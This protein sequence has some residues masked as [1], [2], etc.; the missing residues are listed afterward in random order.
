MTIDDDCMSISVSIS[1]KNVNLNIGFLDLTF[2][3][4]YNISQK[5]GYFGCILTGLDFIVSH[6]R[7]QDLPGL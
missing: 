4:F 7:P 6:Q 5:Y 2:A 3:D 1:L